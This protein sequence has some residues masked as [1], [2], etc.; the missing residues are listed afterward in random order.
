MGG[1]LCPS[2]VLRNTQHRPTVLTVDVAK[3]SKDGVRL[4][5]GAIGRFQGSV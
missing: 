5:V 4:G 2:P 1:N 3:A